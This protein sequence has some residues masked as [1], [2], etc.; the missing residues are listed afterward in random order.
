VRI[1]QEAPKGLGRR[2]TLNR[3]FKML[4]WRHRRGS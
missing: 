4:A 2:P 3:W 1:R